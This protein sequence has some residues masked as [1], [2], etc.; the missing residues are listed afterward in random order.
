[1]VFCHTN[2]KLF[3]CCGNITFLVVRRRNCTKICYMKCKTVGWSVSCCLCCIGVIINVHGSQ[4]RALSIQTRALPLLTDSYKSKLGT[5]YYDL[6]WPRAMYR[7]R[8]TAMTFSH[9]PSKRNTRDSMCQ[10]RDSRILRS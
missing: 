4:F 9:C 10:Q 2:V 1:M 7:W 6:T 8:E 3:H 5:L